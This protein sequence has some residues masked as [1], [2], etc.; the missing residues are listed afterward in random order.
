[1]PVSKCSRSCSKSARG[2]GKEVFTNTQGTLSFEHFLG[3]LGE[4][5]S[6][7]RSSN[8]I[9]KSLNSIGKG[10]ANR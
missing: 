2:K 5:W 6:N 4:F 8:V 7:E 1:M 3:G 10:D 9:Q